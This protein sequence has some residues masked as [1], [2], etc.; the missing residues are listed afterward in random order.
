MSSFRSKSPELLIWALD[1][2][3]P[4]DLVNADIAL[5]ECPQ[6]D[7]G[8]DFIVVIRTSTYADPKLITSPVRYLFVDRTVG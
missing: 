7:D 4:A 2:R 8:D 1:L 5:L 6:I 3:I